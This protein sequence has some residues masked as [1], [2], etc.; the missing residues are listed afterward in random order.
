MSWARRS[1]PARQAVTA[2]DVQ[3]ADGL[4]L[5]D[6]LTESAAPL[7]PVLFPLIKSALTSA[8]RPP[9][10]SAGCWPPADAGHAAA[11]L[12]GLF[13]AI[14]LEYPDHLARYVELDQLTPDAEI[15]GRLLGELAVRRLG[16]P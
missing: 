5:L 11:G 10:G 7:P 4:I 9:P 6:G 14:G 1:R 16:R 13:R 15:A 3:G 12:T 8:R 2:D